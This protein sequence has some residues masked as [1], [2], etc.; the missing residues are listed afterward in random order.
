MAREFLMQH[1]AGQILHGNPLGSNSPFC[2]LSFFKPTDL[3]DSS[4]FWDW[5]TITGDPTITSC[6][7]VSTC[8]TFQASLN[9]LELL[10]TVHGTELSKDACTAVFAWYDELEHTIHRQS[11]S[12]MWRH[13]LPTKFADDVFA[14]SEN[15]AYF[16]GCLPYFSSETRGHDVSQCRMVVA[17]IM[18][19]DTWCAY[20]FDIV[21]KV[22]YILDPSLKQTEK[23]IGAIKHRVIANQMLRAVLACIYLATSY[24]AAGTQP[25]P[26][27]A[28]IP[29]TCLV[30]GA[31]HGL[32]MTYFARYFDGSSV[33]PSL[34]PARLEQHRKDLAYGLTYMQA[35]MS[36]LSNLSAT[37]YLFGP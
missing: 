37:T 15:H 12:P 6:I 27:I 20:C 17:P 7:E 25:W 18:V 9:G 19:R 14:N 8:Q 13:Y 22:T 33:F 23:H 26:M 16:S 2:A 11:N 30:A 32:V 24:D 31:E 10:N 35:N 28:T 29:Q 34:T 36:S 21:R 5:F 3:R 4:I 1:R